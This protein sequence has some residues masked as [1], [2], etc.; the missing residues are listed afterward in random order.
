MFEEEDSV[1]G[2]TT[3]FHVT[4][5]LLPPALHEWGGGGGK[6]GC[7]PDKA[8]VVSDSW[9]A[10]PPATVEGVVDRFSSSQMW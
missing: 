3:F 10:S 7:I 4:M 2:D 9:S 1:D 6:L 8:N 5:F